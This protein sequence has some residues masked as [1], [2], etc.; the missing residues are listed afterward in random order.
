MF[1]NVVKGVGV[2]RPP[3]QN[4]KLKIL[5]WVAELVIELLKANGHETAQTLEE[6]RLALFKRSEELEALKHEQALLEEAL[7]TVRQHN[8]VLE[9]KIKLAK[10]SLG[11]LKAES[12]KKV[13][14]YVESIANQNSVKLYINEDT[15]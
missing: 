10:I 8:S 5:I 1:M 6:N 15:N 11:E 3:Q 7:T 4:M 2:A 12:D 13:L 14:E 9:D